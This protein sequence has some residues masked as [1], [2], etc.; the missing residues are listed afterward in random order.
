MIFPQYFLILATSA[1]FI[2]LTSLASANISRTII[3]NS[4]TVSHNISDITNRYSL[5]QN[6]GIFVG[7]ILGFGIS[8]I[9][10][11]TF[12]YTFSLLTFLAVLNIKVSVN[13]LKYIKLPEL[14]FQ[15]AIIFCL[16]YVQSG[17]KKV[18]CPEEMLNKESILFKGFSNIKFCHSSPEIILNCQKT[19]YVVRI[20]DIFKGKNF[21]IYVKKRKILGL[22]GLK[23]F[24]IYTFLKVNADNNDIFLAFLL[25]VKINLML[26]EQKALNVN[27]KV[28][29]NIVEKATIWLDEIDKKHLF[30]DMKNAGWNLNFNIL[31]EKFYRYHMLI[32][33]V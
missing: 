32:K 27:Y 4:Y 21:I 19:G 3:L 13:S 15:R 12:F 8:F 25:S 7:N 24:D 28:I 1:N 2:K 5:Q 9:I 11:H 10:P 18:I 20:I 33:S 31:E 6:I 23:K 22:L 30:N 16:E 29:S 14:N 26:E 17:C